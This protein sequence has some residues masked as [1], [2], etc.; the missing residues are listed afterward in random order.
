VI[1]TAGNALHLSPGSGDWTPDA[2]GY[3]GFFPYTLFLSSAQKFV[4]DKKRKEKERP[5]RS[6]FLRSKSA[7][8][9]RRELVGASDGLDRRFAVTTTNRRPRRETSAVP[10]AGIPPGVHALENED[11]L[12]VQIVGHAAF[13]A[14]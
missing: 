6:F 8:H 14:A 5:R 3:H 4:G 12:V 2:P 1:R 9:P 7:P 13:D 10:S 11:V